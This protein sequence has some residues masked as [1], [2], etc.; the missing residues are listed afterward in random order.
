MPGNRV[1]LDDRNNPVTENVIKLVKPEMMIV[2]VV[3]AVILAACSPASN[4]DV[5]IA[6]SWITMSDGVRLAADIYWPAGASKKDRFPVLLEYLPYRKDE[7]R[8]RNYSLYSWFL[9]HGYVVARVDIRGTGN[10]GGR[11]IP[12]EYSDIELDDGEAVIAWLARQEWSTGSVGMFGISWGGFNSIQMAM[13]NPPALKAFVAVMATEYLYQEDVHYIDGIV[14]TD[15]WMMSN[16][17]YN[18]LPGAPDFELDEEWQKNR[19]DVEPSV[20]AYMRQQRDGPFWDRASA[21]GQYQ[22]IRVPGYHIGGWYDGYRNS[23]PRMLEYVDAPVK[24]MIGPWDHYFPHNAW[25]EPQVEWRREA[26]RWFDHWLK[27]EDTGVLDEPDFAVYVR[28]YYPPDPGLERVPGHWRWEDGWPVERIVQQSWYASADNGLFVDPAEE[29]MHQMTYKPSMGLEGG[30]PTMWWGSVTPDQQAMDDQ[31][32]TYDSEP[33]KA[34]LEILGR[35]IARLNV[36]ANAPRANWVVR[37]SDVAPDGQVT[38]VAGAAFNG[39]HRNSAREPEDI[40][41]GES[42]PLEINLHFT[43]WVFPEGHR[44]RLAISNAQWPMLWPTPLPM[45]STLAIGGETG[46]RV[47]LPVVPAGAERVPEFKSPVAS[48]ELQGYETLDAGNISGYAALTSIEQDPETAEAFGV[49]SNTGATRYP[50]GVERFE[51]EIEHRT[52]DTNPARTSVVGRYKL[53][54]ELKDRLLEFEQTVDFRSDEENFYLKFHRWVLVNGEL[55][56]EKTWEDVI[57]RDFQ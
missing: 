39:T 19:F 50:W 32:L 46:A 25:P 38:Q 24:A 52:S 9:D 28:N 56:T 42:F 10:S 44:I 13:R 51:E 15:S 53:T 30:G 18:S 16:D 17:L 1:M 55:H 31:G 22:K 2:V 27:G 6:E 40:V 23:L 54:E 35:P 14:H 37:I 26:V 33:L 49:A 3:L 21:R 4:K 11:V 45:S 36:S 34:P 43:S 7:S 29:A 5:E 41:P 12:Y 47:E 57:P 48:P 8:A 20:Y